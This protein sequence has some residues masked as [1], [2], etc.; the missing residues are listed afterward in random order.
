MPTLLSLPREIL[1]KILKLLIEV[2][3]PAPQD[4]SDASNRASLNDFKYEGCFYHGWNNLY[5]EDPPKPDVAS[6]LLVNRQLRAETLD[7]IRLLPTRH[8][9]ILDVLIVEEKEIWPTW[10]YVPVL[11]TRVDRV[12][13]QIRNIGFP[14][15]DRQVQSLYQ[16]G[17]GGPA[18]IAWAYYNLVER[19]LKVGPIGR[20]PGKEDKRISIKELVIDILTPD[21]LPDPKNLEYLKNRL[22]VASERRIRFREGESPFMR[23]P[24]SVANN[25]FM[26]FSGLLSMKRD[27]AHYGG[28]IYDRIGSIK[29][30]V[31]GA[32]L[33]ISEFF[34]GP[35]EWDIADR[36]VKFKYFEGFGDY[37]SSYPENN[38]R[39]AYDQWLK[40]TYKT[41]VEL[42]LPVRPNIE[43]QENSAESK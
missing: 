31:D 27:F 19:F 6:L 24:K 20:Q 4:I 42:G 25:V 17:D 22:R 11:T 13:C 39:A 7:V 10:L 28:L 32:P 36:L 26:G 43:E 1:D 33:R 2:Y 3:T 38:R 16:R 37:S 29:V 23:H 18:A 34:G 5:I 14:T 12:Y 35:A 40:E 15:Q 21:G 30:L 8:S 41:R 9:Y